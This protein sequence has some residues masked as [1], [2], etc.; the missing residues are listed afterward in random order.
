MANDNVRKI[1][2]RI[3]AEGRINRIMADD[4]MQKTEIAM[5]NDNVQKVIIRICAEA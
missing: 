3:C 5:V 1:I 4:N 2:N